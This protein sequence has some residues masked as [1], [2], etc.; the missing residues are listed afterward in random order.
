MCL[1]HGANRFVNC[2]ESL[3]AYRVQRL[4]Y[5]QNLHVKRGISYCTGKLWVLKGIKFGVN[6][7]CLDDCFEK[8]KVAINCVTRSYRIKLNSLELKT[9]FGPNNSRKFGFEGF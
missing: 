6:E 9:S 5:A 4:T 3:P 2:P 7:V 8:I 1:T